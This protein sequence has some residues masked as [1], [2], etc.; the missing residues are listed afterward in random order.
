VAALF[1][2][3]AVSGALPAGGS[4]AVPGARF[5]FEQC[6]PALPGGG[7][8][9]SEHGY[10]AAF[11][12]FQ[13]CAA[14]GGAIGLSVSA[15][16][17]AS[18]GA[19]WVTI[20]ATPEGFVEAE[21]ITT[22]QSGIGPGDP[23]N[24][25]HYSHINENGFPGP[26]PE[27]TRIFHLRD[28]PAFL[29]WNGGSLEIYVSCDGNIGACSPGPALGA[30]YI[31]ATEVDPNPP[32]LA[33]PTGTALSAAILRGHQ[34][35]A[36]EASDVGGGLTS[37]GVLVNGLAVAPTVPGACATAQ[38]S[39]RSTYGTVA[40]SP[41][42][43]PP[44]LAGTWSLDTSA[45]PF[46]DGANTIAVCASDF[47]TLGAPNTTCSPAKTVAVD[48]SCTESPV[49][50]G[51]QISAQFSSS[52]AET[53]TVGYGTA[54]EVTGELQSA[55]GDPISG[56]TICVKSQTLETGEPQAP[57]AAVKTDAAGHFAYAVPAGP[58]RELM[59]GYRHDS[60]QVA[61]D[62]RYYAHAAP[63]LKAGPPKVANGSAVHLWGALPG[64][65][66]GGRVVILQANV[67]GSRRWITFRRATTDEAGA[68]KAGYRFHS[69]T[70][71]T[72]YRFRAIVPRQD[73]YP[74]VEG[75]SAPAP[76]LVHPRHHRHHHR[77]SHK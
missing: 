37:L 17:S 52:N 25:L 5:V 54:A 28:A 73:H 9:N 68:F 46:H 51:S 49:A 70:R 74:Y 29:R 7:V 69:T 59:L 4:A 48:N 57:V 34:S 36:A 11:A 27:E 39:N 47:A 10:D 56:A 53:E 24:P 42:P 40:Y 26:A 18:F 72:R 22:V 55:A 31:A 45:Y 60:F 2:I 71:K 1:V 65:A 33:T 67:V 20:P 19:L 32:V 43:C 76:V 44:R 50:G 12:A 38:V 58:N 16:V 35:L 21:T 6:D 30:H 61:H 14:P 77:R 66:A 63:G 75:H 13:N 15:P 23:A 64:P 3:G 41:S 62:V 8:P